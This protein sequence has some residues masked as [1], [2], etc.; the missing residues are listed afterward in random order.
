MILLY[1]DKKISDVQYRAIFLN[2]L[3]EETFELLINMCI[4]KKVTDFKTTEL[5]AKVKEFCRKDSNVFDCRRSFYNAKQN[6]GETIKEFDVRLKNL[7]GKCQFGAR[8]QESLKDIFVLGIRTFKIQE[9]ILNDCEQSSYE[10][11]VKLAA[12]C[13]SLVISRSQGTRYSEN[14]NS[15]KKGDSRRIYSK[16][17]PRG[18]AQVHQMKNDTANHR[19]KIRDKNEVICFRC[20]LKGHK[21]PNCKVNLD[22]KVHKNK[23]VTCS[24]SENNTFKVKVF[25]NSINLKCVLDTGAFISVMPEFIYR[26]HFSDVK[27]EKYKIQ[28]NAYGNFSLPVLGSINLFVKYNNKE[29]LVKFIVVKD[30]REILLGGNFFKSF[31]ITIDGIHYSESEIPSVSGSN[32]KV[33]NNLVKSVKNCNAN[34]DSPI[35]TKLTSINRYRQRTSGSYGRKNSNFSFANLGEKILVKDFKPINERNWVFGKVY[36]IISQNV[37]LV[38]VGNK[39]WKRHSSQLQVLNSE[40]NYCSDK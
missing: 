30:G 18:N 35:K 7:A 11:T 13:E 20:G 10:D 21:K 9:K 36:K 22:K 17:N 8:L 23:N 29:H 39:I 3:C 19:K 5:L 33:I 2:L 27:L 1:D 15:V 4:P 28:V 12:M 37:F 26:K 25:L 14:V 24:S 16:L 32:D 6:Y 38:K 34:L 31:N 40:R